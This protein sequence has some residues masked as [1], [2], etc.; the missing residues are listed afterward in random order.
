LTCGF[1]KHRRRPNGVPFV[2]SNGASLLSHRSAGKSQANRAGRERNRC[3][4][5]HRF[6]NKHSP[7]F[8]IVAYHFSEQEADQ[9]KEVTHHS[10]LRKCGTVDWAGGIFTPVGAN[11]RA[12]SPF[13]RIFF[14][15]RVRIGNLEALGRVRARRFNFTGA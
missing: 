5:K 12:M 8:T 15:D 2:K 4:P 1:L 11:A 6:S 3:K 10:A 14:R 7:L 13:F 9:G